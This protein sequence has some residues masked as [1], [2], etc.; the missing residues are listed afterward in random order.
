MKTKE[1]MKS[2]TGVSCK[3]RI[4]FFCYRYYDEILVYKLLNCSIYLAESVHK[5]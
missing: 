1:T 2:I 3:I 5:F 4:T